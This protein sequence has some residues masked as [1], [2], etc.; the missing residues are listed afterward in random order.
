MR[1]VKL[2]LGADDLVELLGGDEAG[3]EGRLAEGDALLVRVLGDLGGVVITNGRVQARNQ[4]N[5]APSASA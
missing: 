4:H 1:N 3:L 5:W 2:T